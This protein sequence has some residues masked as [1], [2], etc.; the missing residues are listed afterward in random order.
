MLRFIELHLVPLNS[1][2]PSSLLLSSENYYGH[3]STPKYCL[4]EEEAKTEY[5]PKCLEYMLPFQQNN[6]TIINVLY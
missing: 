2:H 6:T 5:N 3:V 1:L 4:T